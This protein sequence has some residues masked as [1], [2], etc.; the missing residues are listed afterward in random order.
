[1]A[2]PELPRKHS[3]PDRC[4]HLKASGITSRMRILARSG[5]G[6]HLDRMCSSAHVCVGTGRQSAHLFMVQYH[7][8][9]WHIAIFTFGWCLSVWMTQKC[10]IPW[11][12][13]LELEKAFTIHSCHLQLNIEQ[14]GL[15]NIVIS[16]DKS[17]LCLLLMPDLSVT[18][19]GKKD[20]LLLLR[21]IVC[22]QVMIY[23]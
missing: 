1:M 11:L 22:D 21:M 6:L 18:F 9:H 12:R 15:V 8:V 17:H 16:V 2:V 13:F 20:L 19:C 14:N 23:N 5:G 3:S 4:Q 7:C 10:L